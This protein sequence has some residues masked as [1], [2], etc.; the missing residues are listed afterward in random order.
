MIQ[1]RQGTHDARVGKVRISKRFGE[2]TSKDLQRLEKYHRACRILTNDI[3][4]QV[5][6][7]VNEFE[8]YLRRIAELGGS[9]K[10]EVEVV[11]GTGENVRFYDPDG[12]RL[13]LWRTTAQK[14]SKAL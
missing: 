7:L 12:N 6:I 10:G 3:A 9:S 2:L 4:S 1:S 14:E 8:S 5:Y 11:A 13:A